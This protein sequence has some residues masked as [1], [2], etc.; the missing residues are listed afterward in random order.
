MPQVTRSI[1]AE[2]EPHKAVILCLRF[3]SAWC[4]KIFQGGTDGE[5]ISTECR[6]RYRLGNL[7]LITLNRLSMSG[8]LSY[9]HR[10]PE[11]TTTTE[12]VR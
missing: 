6:R 11:G 10:A 9:L 1:S 12:I 2:A 7:A 5:L 3:A 8:N 4:L